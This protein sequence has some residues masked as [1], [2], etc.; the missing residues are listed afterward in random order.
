[1]DRI[2][3]F[4]IVVMLWIIP[5]IVGYNSGY[6]FIWCVVAVFVSIFAHFVV[7]FIAFGVDGVKYI[8]DANNITEI[9]I[10]FV[11]A[12]GCIKSWESFPPR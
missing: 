5:A 4:V 11:D 3:T 9:L 8:L 10:R 1:M 7:V 12:L 6:S 2:L